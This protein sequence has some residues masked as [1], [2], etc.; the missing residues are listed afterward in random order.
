M[1]WLRRSTESHSRVGGIAL[2]T[3]QETVTCDEFLVERPDD[4]EGVCCSF[5]EESAI[6]IGTA[7]Q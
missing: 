6:E 7:K 1:G 5:E 4:L 3:N 2:S